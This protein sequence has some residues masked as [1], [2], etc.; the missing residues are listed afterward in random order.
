MF[1]YLSVPPVF[2]RVMGAKGIEGGP[3]SL[4]CVARGDPVPDMVWVNVKT[5][6]RFT[7]GTSNN[8]SLCCNGNVHTVC[9]ESHVQFMVMIVGK[10]IYWEKLISFQMSR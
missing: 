3:A 5:G 10:L 4:T 7:E 9:S 6:D 8:V 1:K 2:E